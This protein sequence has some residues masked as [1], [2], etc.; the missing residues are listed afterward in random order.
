[1]SD[2]TPGEIARKFDELERRVGSKL[3]REL[4]EA[5][6][7]SLVEDIGEI[8]MGLRELAASLVAYQKE[9]REARRSMQTVV[10]AQ[11]IALIVGIVLTL[12][13]RI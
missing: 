11:F 9:E 12:I 8:K 13:G 4:Y 2:L 6:R 10:V 3:S 1:M 7:L 5:Q